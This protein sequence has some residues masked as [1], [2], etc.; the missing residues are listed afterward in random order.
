MRPSSV[1]PRY[2]DARGRLAREPRRLLRKLKQ[3]SP[4][5]HGHRRPSA[6]QPLPLCRLVSGGVAGWERA[7]DRR[8]IATRRKPG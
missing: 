7:R 8:I 2:L 4:A 5:L 3:R 6:P 1:H